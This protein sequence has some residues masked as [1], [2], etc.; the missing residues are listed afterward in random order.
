MGVLIYCVS[1]LSPGCLLGSTDSVERPLRIP[2][3]VCYIQ[4]CFNRSGRSYV[5]HR[6]PY[7]CVRERASSER[8]VWSPNRHHGGLYLRVHRVGYRSFASRVVGRV[9]PRTRGQR[10][11]DRVSH[12]HRRRSGSRIAWG[13]WFQVRSYAVPL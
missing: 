1:L 11:H 5:P 2:P 8:M 6:F 9:H 13:E 3:V 12:Q 7:H 4:G 10:V